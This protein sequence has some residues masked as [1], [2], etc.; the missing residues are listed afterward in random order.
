MIFVQIEKQVKNP[1]TLCHSV[2]EPLFK[3]VSTSIAALAQQ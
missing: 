3:N 2:S 1:P